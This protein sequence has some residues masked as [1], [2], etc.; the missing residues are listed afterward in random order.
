MLW[1]A[2]KDY[3]KCRVLLNYFSVNYSCIKIGIGFEVVRRVV[4]HIMLQGKQEK[5]GKKIKAPLDHDYFFYQDKQFA[6][7][8]EQVTIRRSEKNF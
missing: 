5:N 4:S 8:C 1:E 6:D 7:G 2:S 3:R